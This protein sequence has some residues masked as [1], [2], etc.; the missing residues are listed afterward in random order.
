MIQEEDEDEHNALLGGGL[1]DAPPAP[2]GSLGGRSGSALAG[3]AL[4]MRSGDSGTPRRAES[5]FTIRTA[6][7]EDGRPWSGQVREVSV[8]LTIDR[9]WWTSFTD[10]LIP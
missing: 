3:A 10:L 5:P 9:A 1:D 6:D 2:A 7:S 8:A 4:A